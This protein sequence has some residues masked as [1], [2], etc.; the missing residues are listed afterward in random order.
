MDKQTNVYCKRTS[1]ELR[2]GFVGAG[3]H[4]EDEV[5]DNSHDQFL[6]CLKKM[7]KEIHNWKIIFY[8]LILSKKSSSN[9]RASHF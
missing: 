1:D 2:W 8:L 3:D 9:Y 6:V 5:C 7:A 4:S